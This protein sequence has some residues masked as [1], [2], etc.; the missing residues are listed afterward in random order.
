M[1]QE[2]DRLEEMIGCRIRADRDDCRLQEFIKGVCNYDADLTKLILCRNPLTLEAAIDLFKEH[3][4]SFKLKSAIVTHD[5]IGSSVTE[6]P[7]NDLN[8]QSSSSR[9]SPESTNGGK[10]PTSGARKITINMTTEGFQVLE[11][12]LREYIK[13]TPSLSSKLGNEVNNLEIEEVGDVPANGAAA[14][15]CE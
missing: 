2:L 1:W 14:T 9:G 13:V 8:H 11:K 10:S 6:S 7:Q 15:G 4:Y 12:S 5:I 3:E